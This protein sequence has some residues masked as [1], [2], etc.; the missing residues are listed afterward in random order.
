MAGGPVPCPYAER[1][2]LF[3]SNGLPDT[4]LDIV[5]FVG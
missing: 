1:F 2:S 4:V 5:I 3:G